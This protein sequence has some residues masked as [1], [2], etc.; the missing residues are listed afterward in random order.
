VWYG[1]MGWVYGYGCYCG[2]NGGGGWWWAI[3]AKLLLDCG[4]VGGDGWWC[5]VCARS[6]AKFLCVREYVGRYGGC[7]VDRK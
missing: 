6:H 2:G 7:L 5:G 3:D 4:C 1:M